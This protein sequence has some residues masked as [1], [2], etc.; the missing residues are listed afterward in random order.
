ML[1]FTSAWGG[2]VCIPD[3]KKVSFIEAVNAPADRP[4]S[5]RCEITVEGKVYM[6]SNRYNDVKEAVNSALHPPGGL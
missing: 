6:L 3:A 4:D 2:L 5:L 1:E